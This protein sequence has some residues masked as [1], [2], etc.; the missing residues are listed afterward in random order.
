MEKNKTEQPMEL[1]S[2]DSTLRELKETVDSLPRT[3]HMTLP[4]IQIA[5]IDDE[6]KA[7]MEAIS[8][9]NNA[10][11]SDEVVTEDGRTLQEIRNE[12]EFGVTDLSDEG[13]KHKL[14]LSKDSEGNETLKVQGAYDKAEE[15]IEIKATPANIAPVDVD[16]PH[17]PVEAKEAGHKT[18]APISGD[19]VK[20]ATFSGGGTGTTGTGSGTASSGMPS[21]NPSGEGGTSGSTGTVGNATP[22]SNPSGGAGTTAGTGGTGSGGSGGSGGTGSI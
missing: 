21:S 15:A 3:D 9:I 18:N 14:T 22:S 11:K 1:T 12:F 20:G 8:K 6:T 17:N 10:T 4:A 19:P 7:R 2:T 13:F 16:A 5:K